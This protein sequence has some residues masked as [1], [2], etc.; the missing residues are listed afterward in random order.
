M[1]TTLKS[2][3]RSQLKVLT[4][5]TSTILWHYHIIKV[6][7]KEKSF[8]RDKVAC[9]PQTASGFNANLKNRKKG[10]RIEIV[11]L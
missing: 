1:I 10:L 7:S 2:A 6:S 5:S 3:T 8:G 11:G 4:L 9:L